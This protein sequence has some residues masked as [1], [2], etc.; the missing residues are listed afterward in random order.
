[1]T[2]G[3]VSRGLGRSG[4]QRERRS[5]SAV[6]RAESA[7]RS[8]GKSRNE[9]SQPSRKSKEMSMAQRASRASI[10]DSAAERLSAAPGA[11]AAPAK[12]QGGGLW[13]IAF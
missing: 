8:G 13:F 1:M 7:T 6:R 10:T 3:M 9:F 4:A 2:K 12:H 5:R 11:A